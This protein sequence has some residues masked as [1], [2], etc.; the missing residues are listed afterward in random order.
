MHLAQTPMPPMSTQLHGWAPPLEGIR[1]LSVPPSLPPQHLL[2][3]CQR[4]GLGTF[5][6]GDPWTCPP[7]GQSSYEIWVSTCLPL[8]AQGG[9][10]CR[11]RDVLMMF[12]LELA[13]KGQVKRACQAGP[14]T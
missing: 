11:E 4:K 2:Y 9:L 7:K 8:P 1:K 13:A 5:C 14:Q 10:L 3:F 6:L 12:I